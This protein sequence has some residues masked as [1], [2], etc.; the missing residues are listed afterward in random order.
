MEKKTFTASQLLIALAI[1]YRGNW[2]KIMNAVS[3]HEEPDDAA[4]VQAVTGA[5][6]A[7]TLLDP[8]YPTILKSVLKPPFVLF[9]KGNI[10]LLKQKCMAVIGTRSP[11]AYGE[12]MTTQLVKD[13][14][15]NGYIIISGLGLGIST[16]AHKAAIQ[17]KG[18]TIAVVGSG[19]DYYYPQSNKVL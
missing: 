16:I 7:I 19:L 10:K 8:E 12:K 1:Q 3:R 11:T 5:Q 2:M 14:T 15:N 9:Y 6:K 4:L 13:L 18:K 17:N